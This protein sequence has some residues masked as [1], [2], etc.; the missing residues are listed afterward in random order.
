MNIFEI[1]KT[2]V[3]PLF[4]P[5]WHL[6]KKWTK[7]SYD[8]PVKYWKKRHKKYGLDFQG[9]GNCTL[10]HDENVAMY[11]VAK[12]CFLD[13]CHR[14]NV[15][16][17]NIKVLDIGC[18]NGFYTKVFHESSIEHYLGI[19]ITDVLFKQLHKEFPLYRFEQC[20]ITNEMLEN[21]FDLIIMID[22]TQHIVDNDKFYFAMKN[23]KE[24]L[25]PNGVFIV[26]AWLSETFTQ[27]TYYEV[28]RPMAY[29]QKAFENHLISEPVP[30]RDKY[31][32]SIRAPS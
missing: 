28:A 31:I 25:T 11:D 19:D 27:R 14:E 24:H 9:V 20:D 7:P 29:Y 2:T 21:N 16:K 22:V 23:I 15:L 32:F 5:Y 12:T 18:G 17:P 13:V 1:I 8:D 30:F 26:T 3:K 10:T 6:R 4:M